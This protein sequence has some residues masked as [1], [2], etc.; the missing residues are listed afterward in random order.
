MGAPEAGGGPLPAAQ[1]AQCH[2]SQMP[3]TLGA[4]CCICFSSVQGK[5]SGDMRGGE[6]RR[7]SSWQAEG[8]RWE[9]ALL[10]EC[11]EADEERVG[12]R[13]GAILPPSS[14]PWLGWDP[15]SCALG[16][17]PPSTGVTE[18]V[19]RPQ[20]VDG[21]RGTEESGGRKKGE[22]KVG[23]LPRLPGQPGLK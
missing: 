9:A 12:I 19:V 22:P 20:P 16:L 7:S 21:F 23:R 18:T 14:P 3:V 2:I 13:F 17:S 10:A 4:I 5:Q 6:G 8:W 11:Q 15:T 1:G